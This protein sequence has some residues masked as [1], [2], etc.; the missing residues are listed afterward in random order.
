MSIKVITLNTKVTDIMGVMGSR[1]SPWQPVMDMTLGHFVKYGMRTP[2]FGR[3]KYKQV[4][5]TAVFHDYI[6]YD[7]REYILEYVI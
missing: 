2:R 4:I 5:R 7:T 6:D 1:Y 3:V